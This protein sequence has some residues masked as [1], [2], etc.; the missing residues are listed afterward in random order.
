[1][2]NSARLPMP[3]GE[4]SAQKLR[5]L[6]APAPDGVLNAHRVSLKVNKPA[7]NTPECVAPFDAG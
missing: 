2:A 5:E 1:M 7:F 3:I 6:F 4:R